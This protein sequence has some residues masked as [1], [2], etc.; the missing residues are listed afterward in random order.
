MLL[1]K[2]INT[3]CNLRLWIV[4]I[5]MLPLKYRFNL[6]KNVVCL[7]PC[8]YETLRIKLNCLRR[9]QRL[10]VEKVEIHFQIDKTQYYIEL[11]YTYKLNI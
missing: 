10:F 8:N 5:T 7:W 6:L 9:N 3:S 2:N 4:R 1:V 11:S